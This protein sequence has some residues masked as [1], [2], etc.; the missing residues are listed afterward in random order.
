[1]NLHSAVM[2][3]QNVLVAIQSEISNK[4]RY[5]LFYKY[6]ARSNILSMQANYDESH[7]NPNYPSEF[8][9][10]QSEDNKTEVEASTTS[11]DKGNADEYGNEHFKFPLPDFPLTQTA[12]NE[13]N[14]KVEEET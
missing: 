8:V 11:K 1:M 10:N 6:I 7:S 13:F 3:L 12:L 14:K 4:V 5:S 9:S 2:Y